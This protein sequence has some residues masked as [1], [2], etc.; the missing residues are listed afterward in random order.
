ML[1]YNEQIIDFL[2]IH[3]TP[4]DDN[5]ANIKWST[6]QLLEFL[7]DVFPKNCISDYDLIEILMELGYQRFTW[8]EDSI[9]KV[10]EGDDETFTITK[11]LATGW[12]LRTDLDLNTEEITGK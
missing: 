1:N 10:G 7:F 8:T 5:R 9:S 4:T 3:F 12:C 11:S 6:N 2:R